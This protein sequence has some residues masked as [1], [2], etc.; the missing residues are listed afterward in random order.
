MSRVSA[1]DPGSASGAAKAL[2]ERIWEET[3][4]VPALLRAMAHSPAVL[5]GYLAIQERLDGGALD[6]RLRYHIA[7][8]VSQANGSEYCVA[9]YSAL[10]KAAGLSEEAVRDAR[11]ASSPDRRT[12]TVLKFA[13][14]LQSGAGQAISRHLPRLRDVGLGDTEIVEVVAHVMIVSLANALYHVSDVAVDFPP[15]DLKELDP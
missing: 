2:L 7:L 4:M 15:V 6:T 11:R 9:A 14:A 12:D 10:G 13:R 5:D 3:G 8:S 1:I